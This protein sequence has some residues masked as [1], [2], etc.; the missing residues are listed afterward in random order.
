MRLLLDTHVVLWWLADS[1]ALSGQ[2]ASA[3]ERGGGYVSAASVWEI[4]IKRAL[5]KLEAPEDLAEVV[6]ASNLLRLPIQFEHALIVGAL[7]HHHRDPFDRMLIAQA[8]HEGLTLV[9]SDALIM[10]YPVRVLPAS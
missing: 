4:A 9:T 1:P 2:A 5:G 10:R 7:P 8:Q 6:D 3:I